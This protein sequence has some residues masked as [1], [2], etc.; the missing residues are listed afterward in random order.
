MVMR[1][2][3]LKNIQVVSQK[4]LDGRSG[5]WIDGEGDFGNLSWELIHHVGQNFSVI[6]IKIETGKKHQIRNQLVLGG[7]GPLIG[8]TRYGYTGARPKG[9]SLQSIMLHASKISFE[10]PTHHGE[11]VSA[12]CGPTWPNEFVPIYLQGEGNKS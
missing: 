5:G 12:S 4:N 10:H 1:K 7:L 3:L 6:R 11:I 9:I 2:Y 8:D